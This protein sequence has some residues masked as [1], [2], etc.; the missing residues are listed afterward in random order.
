MD[1]GSLHTPAVSDDAVPGKVGAADAPRSLLGGY[2]GWR[3]VDRNR[4]K[5]LLML[6]AFCVVY[7]FFIAIF[8]GAVMA[9]VVLPLV[10]LAGLVIWLLPDGAT[11]PT[12]TMYRL[13]MAYM[14]AY[15]VWPD[16][17]ALSLPG[18]PWISAIR[19]IGFPLVAMFLISL[20]TSSQYRRELSDVLAGAPWL[21]RMVLI[22]MGFSVF[23]LIVST[24]FA[25]SM[26]KLVVA[27]I[28]LFAMFFIS[29]HT[30]RKPGRA[31]L[32]IYLMWG[33]MVFNCFI[34]LWEAR[35]QQLPWAG[36]IPQFLQIQDPTVLKMFKFRARAASGAYRVQ[37]KFTTPLGLAEFIVLVMPLVIHIALSTRK[38]LV[39]LAAIATLPMA[40]MTLLATDSRLGLSGFMMA[41]LLYLF[42]WGL[43]QWRNH[44]DSIFGPAVLIGYPFMFIG[45][46]AA[47]FF[48]G[49]LK[50]MVWG[51]GAQ[52]FSSNS[53]ALQWAMGIPKIFAR[54]F[55]YGIGQ[56][57]VTLQFYNG[58]DLSV[59]SYFL[60]ALLEYGILGFASFIGVL[61]SAMGYGAAGVF[62]AR[63]EEDRL[64]VPLSIALINFLVIKAV[65]T[66]V[67]NHSLVFIYLG[68]VCALA[69][70]VLTRG[71]A[72]AGDGSVAEPER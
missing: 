14:V 16:Y 64:L 60:T 11:A 59:D 34:G 38:V 30:F 32:F 37:G 36:H 21:A 48:V 28:Y 41:C 27:M 9:V 20:S 68:C 17:V 50:L 18:L 3:F 66:Q 15:L 69:G 40:F 46:L 23:S 61:V 7:G 67:E 70:R 56:S 72:V 49:K 33:I 53:R 51:G 45:F 24:S 47:T 29:A 31:T 65:F 22:F 5:L 42:A 26:N 71:K 52:Q 35:L 25:N 6:A 44:K 63:E 1:S 19:L 57:A 12:V 43:L 8:M 4:R 58:D 39:R 2:V 54:P 13:L 10:V 62:Y 55:G